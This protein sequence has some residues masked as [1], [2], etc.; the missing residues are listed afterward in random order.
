M[1]FDGA[2][3]G[4]G[5]CTPASR[6]GRGPRAGAGEAA[7]L[8]GEVPLGGLVGVVDEHEAGVGAEAAGLL[9]HGLLVLCDEACAEEFDER[10]DEGDVVADVPGG[11]DVD[12]AGGGR[13]GRDG[14]EGGE[15]AGFGVTGF[16]GWVIRGSLGFALTRFA[17]DDGLNLPVEMTSSLGAG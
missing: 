1:E 12:A 13:D 4:V 15:P 3:E 6:A 16:G 10:G 14:G 11:D 7:L 5:A 17:R 9:D 2:G 8:E